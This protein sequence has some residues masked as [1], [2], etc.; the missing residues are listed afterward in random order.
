MQLLAT[1]GYAV[2]APDSPL[3]TG[4]P[5]TDLLKTILPGV[6]RVIDMGIADPDRLGVMGHSYGGYS[7]LSLI[8]QTT[9]F[10]AAVDSAGP[11]NLISFYGQ[12]DPSGSSFALGWAETGQGGMEG[13]PWQFRERYIENSPIFYLNRVQTPVLI[14]QG[15]LD[16]AVPEE[17]SDEVFIG[18][19]RLGKEVEY[20]KYGGEEHWEGSWALSNVI[21]Y[22]N[23]VIRWFDGHLKGDEHLGSK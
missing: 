16:H 12:M 22:W 4:T 3:R 8:V 7:T 23:R 14:V 13:T 6:D 17:Q 20:A 18:L 1:R 10:R 2:L 9:R 19:R 15:R 21:D 11:A 5:M